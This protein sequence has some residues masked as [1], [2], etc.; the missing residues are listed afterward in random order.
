[1]FNFFK[2]PPVLKRRMIG[3]K[4]QKW[5]YPNSRVD[6]DDDY[7]YYL[8]L[9]NG[10]AFTSVFSILYVISFVTG[11]PIDL[12]FMTISIDPDDKAMSVGY[13][14]SQKIAP[15]VLAVFLPY[16][17]LLFKANIDMRSYDLLKRVPKFV[18]RTSG[19]RGKIIKWSLLIVIFAFLGMFGAF[20]GPAWILDHHLS[21]N[22]ST[23]LLIMFLLIYPVLFA[24]RHNHDS[25]GP[26]HGLPALAALRPL[27]QSQTYR[28]EIP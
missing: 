23:A 1:M 12:Y 26:C 11:H 16:A 6:R 2:L 4:I 15:V 14:F 7:I 13:A 19:K 20:A 28:K 5:F 27:L 10:F 24:R 8:L 22:D 9:R 21:T 18:E 17:W 25:Y 3:G